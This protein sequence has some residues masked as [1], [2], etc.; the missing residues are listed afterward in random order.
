MSSASTLYAH[1]HVSDFNDV[2]GP[3]PLVGKKMV[4]S[5]CAHS[6]ANRHGAIEGLGFFRFP[7]QPE[8]RQRWIV[9]V[10]RKDWSPRKHTRICGQHFVSG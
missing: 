2:I 5:C 4:V 6:C 3:H 8:K 7:V 1:P 10:N 9:A